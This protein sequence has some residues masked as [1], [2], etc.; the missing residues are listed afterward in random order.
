MLSDIV[1]KDRIETVSRSPGLIAFWSFEGASASDVVSRCDPSLGMASLP[2]LLSQL[3]DDKA[4]PVSQWPYADDAARLAF[5]AD[6]QFGRSIRLNQGHIFGIVPRTLFEGSLLD[7][8]RRQAFTMVAWLRFTGER[9]LIGGIWDEGGWDRYGGRRQAALFAGLFGQRGTIAHVSATGAACYPQSNA[10]G[11]Q[12]ARTRAIDGATIETGEW[13]SLAMTFDPVLGEVTAYKNGVATPISLTDPVMADALGIDAALPANPIQFPAKI[14]HPDSTLL[15][16]SGYDYKT[17]PVAEHRLTID[18]ARG[19]IEYQQAGKRDASLFRVRGKIVTNGI[20]EFELNEA[21]MSGSFEPSAYGNVA[22]SLEVQ[23]GGGWRQAA[24][25]VYFTVEDGA[26]FT[27]GRA[28]G[29]GDHGHDFGSQMDLSG[30]AVF[31]RTLS[32][33]ELTNIAFSPNC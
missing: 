28:P 4:Y 20:V 16:F 25:D 31:N 22:A 5:P 1:A 13:V 2:F 11:A 3:G 21:M 23:T 30:F 15:K 12:Y 6:G 26:P 10:D 7:I 9:H 33:G 27:F 29:V 8:N 17:G 18:F 32:S 24:D 14:F 19:S